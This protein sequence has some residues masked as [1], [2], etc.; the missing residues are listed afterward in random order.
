[1]SSTPSL[2]AAIVLVAF[3]ALYALRAW[4]PSRFGMSDRI[5][6]LAESVGLLALFTVLHFFTGWAGVPPVLW[7]IAAAAAAAGVALL[8]VKFGALPW[9]RTRRRLWLRIVRLT[10][11]AV[12]SSGVFALG[13]MAFSG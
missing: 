4:K 12:V 10:L 9:V 1:M 7:I 13:A 8:V 11:A 6:A 5:G 3:A 2:A